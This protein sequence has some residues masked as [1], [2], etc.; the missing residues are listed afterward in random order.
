MFVLR[1]WGETCPKS[2]MESSHNI[3]RTKTVMEEAG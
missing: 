2:A 3:V 1:L